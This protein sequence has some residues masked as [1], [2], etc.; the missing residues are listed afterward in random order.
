MAA[1]A[2]VIDVESGKQIDLGAELGPEQDLAK[3]ASTKIEDTLDDELPR[4]TELLPD[5]GGARDGRLVIGRKFTA[6]AC[7][8]CSDG[9]WSSYSRSVVLPSPRL[10]RSLAP[11]ARL[12]EGL[13]RFRKEN[14]TW[15][16]GGFSVI[17]GR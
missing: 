11:F 6:F 2:H 17:S 14:P 15:P 1:E 13:T 4:R 8:A 10:P 3:L 7:Y 12:P 9:D 5:I 16:V